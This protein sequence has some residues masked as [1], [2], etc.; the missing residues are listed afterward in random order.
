MLVLET[1]PSVNFNRFFEFFVCYNNCTLF[2]TNNKLTG[3]LWTILECSCTD[4]NFLSLRIIV[5]NLQRLNSVF[6]ELSRIPEMGET[7]SRH[8]NTLETSLSHLPLEV[9]N[10]IM[11]WLL[12][13][14]QSNWLFTFTVIPNTNNTIRTTTPDYVGKFVIER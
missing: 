10:W 3:R 7:I 5:S 13:V 2:S 4:D 11:M 12:Y 14:G 1:K 8:W 9:S 6:F